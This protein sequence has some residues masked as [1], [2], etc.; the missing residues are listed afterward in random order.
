MANTP[1]P[2][3]TEKHRPLLRW[4]LSLLALLVAS[5][6]GAAWYRQ[7]PDASPVASAGPPP[8][9]V[10]VDV[11]QQGSIPVYLDGLGTVQA[12]NFVTVKPQVD[13]PL[14]NILFDEG[15]TVK[16]GDLLAVIDPR[17][18]KAAVEQATA[19]LEQDR[20]NLTNAQYLL[21]KDQ[22][23]A[24]QQITTAEQVETQQSL[25]ASLQAQLAQ[26]QA[27][28]DLASL[29]LS[30]TELR[31]PI[32]GRTGFQLVDVG[33]QVHTTDADGIVTITQ[34][35]PISVESTLSE[36]DFPAVRAAMKAGPVEVTALTGDGRTLLATGTLSSVDNQID[37]S[38]GTARLKSTFANADEALWP[39]QFVD[40]RIRQKVLDNAINVPSPALQRG[41]NGFF[42]YI[43]NADDT[44]AVRPVTPGPIDAGRAVIDS[45]LTP[46]ERVVT[47][48]QYRLAP[49]VKIAAQDPVAASAPATKE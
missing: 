12:F 41:P 11:V 1:L 43:V 14:E 30:Y 44:V 20:A 34:T 3:D 31:A 45:G 24:T 27:A 36:N 15:Q 37:Q 26:D 9:P 40:I 16:K 46:G 13:G 39:G 4:S 17:P 49:G 47:S 35:Q 8:V 7:H 33:N 19:K 22:Q 6:V 21:E 42:V 23:L 28:K 18:F 48:G 2:L 38:S 5:V 32:D 25:V 29:Q 10:Q